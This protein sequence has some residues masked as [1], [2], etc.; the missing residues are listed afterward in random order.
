MRTESDYDRYYYQPQPNQHHSH[1]RNCV[2]CN[3]NQR[4]YAYD[5]DT[6]AIA[7]RY[8]A[9]ARPV[10]YS[11]YDDYYHRRGGYDN[12]NF[13]PFDESYRYVM[14]V[15]LSLQLHEHFTN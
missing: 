14:C 11:S 8:I 15:G 1:P 7:G 4:G 3:Y 5:Y 10:S 13:R 2:N 6:P 12:R 9:P